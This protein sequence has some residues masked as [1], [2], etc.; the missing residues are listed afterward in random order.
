MAKDASGADGAPTKKKSILPILIVLVLVFAGGGFFAMKTFGSKKA[1]DPGLQ[2]GEI[3][4]LE[5]FLTNTGNGDYYIRT[6]IALH[7]AKG[8]D[9]HLVD[10]NMPAIRDRILLV[11]SRQDIDELS[12]VDGKVALK[13][14][15]AE[16]VNAVLEKMASASG[17]GKEKAESGSKETD[18][19]KGEPENPDWDSQTGPVLKVYFTSF[20]TQAA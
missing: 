3:V 6:E 12:T 5:E 2:L 13:R 10:A 4:A 18:E 8:V 20:A 11:L 19:K 1:P 7:L 9:K 15:I 17:H 14:E 16:E